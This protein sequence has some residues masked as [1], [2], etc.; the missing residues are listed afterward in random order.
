[1]T[2]N[3]R[4]WSA[5]P[6]NLHQVRHLKHAPDIT[7]A[8]LLGAH[9]VDLNTERLKRNGKLPACWQEQRRALGLPGLNVVGHAH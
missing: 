4:D 2:P 3:D 5:H 6:G 7:R 9:P 8:I 1:M